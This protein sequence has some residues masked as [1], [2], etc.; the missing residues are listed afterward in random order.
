MTTILQTLALFFVPV[1]FTTLYPRYFVSNT[2]LFIGY[3][4]VI[5]RT[6]LP[7]RPQQCTNWEV[8]VK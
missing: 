1:I 7:T 5:Y 4:T 6:C 2:Q 8:Q 3:A